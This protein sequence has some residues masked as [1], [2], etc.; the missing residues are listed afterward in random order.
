MSIARE[1]AKKLLEEI[2]ENASW[3]DI[4]YQ[5]YVRKKIDTALD[6]ADA[7]EVVPHEDVKKRFAAS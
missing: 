1:E 7:G 2:P 6:A 5:F 3:D 4:M